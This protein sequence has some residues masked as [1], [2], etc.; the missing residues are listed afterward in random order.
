MEKYKT[1]AK[2]QQIRENNNNGKQNKKLLNK[3]IAKTFAA[4]CWRFQC[5]CVW[6]W[7]CFLYYFCYKRGHSKKILLLRNKKFYAQT[8]YHSQAHTQT[9][10]Q[11]YH[12]LSHSFFFVSSLSLSVVK[13]FACRPIIFAMCTQTMTVRRCFE[14][15][16]SNVRSHKRTHS[17]RPILLLRIE[18]PFEQ[19][20]CSL[21]LQSH[22]LTLSLTLSL[23]LVHCLHHHHHCLSLHLSIYICS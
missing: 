16:H 19:L 3:W 17:R 8:T 7:V 21:H 14:R 23:A 11:N 20:A 2:K 6:W 1:T 4:V 9:H 18:K 10:I 22:S 12:T 13:V 15:I 5:I